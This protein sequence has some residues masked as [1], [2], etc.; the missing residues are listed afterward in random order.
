MPSTVKITHRYE[1]LEIRTGE[2]GGAGEK[3]TLR[4]RNNLIHAHLHLCF[5]SCPRTLAHWVVLR[6]A[7]SP[8][9]HVGSRNRSSEAL[10]YPPPC[11]PFT[12]SSPPASR[13]PPNTYNI[14]LALCSCPAVGP[15]RDQESLAALG[16]PSSL[17]ISQKLWSQEL[18]VSTLLL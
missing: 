2:G 8:W 18:P 10:Y 6:G 11:H 12:P 15:H 9:T 5:L 17:P 3:N 16:S 14:H 4:S 13:C 1:T 7:G